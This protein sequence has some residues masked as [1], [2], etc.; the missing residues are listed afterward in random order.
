MISNELQFDYGPIEGH[1]PIEALEAIAKENKWPLER[2]ANDEASLECEGRWGQFTLGFLWQEEFQSLQFCCASNLRVT[3]AKRNAIKDLMFEINQKTWL[4]HF[5]VDESDGAIIFRYTS[6]MR[7]FS[8]HVHEHIE[9]MIDMAMTE[10][11]RFYPAFK[12]TLTERKV[13]N[14]VMLTM[15]ADT[16]GEA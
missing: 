8:L 5:S 2:I 9:D 1:N 16:M 7:G 4:G 12:A 11:D 10:F 15:L 13:A 3:A 14:D 6:L